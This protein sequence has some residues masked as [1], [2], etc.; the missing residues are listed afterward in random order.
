MK[1]VGRI[2]IALL[3]SIAAFIG[4]LYLASFLILPLGLNYHDGWTVFGAFLIALAASSGT[5]IISMRKTKSH[6]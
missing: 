1:L 4:A 3:F 5:F 2:L 6:A